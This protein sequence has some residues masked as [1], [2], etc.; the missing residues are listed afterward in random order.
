MSS[1]PQESQFAHEILQ[2]YHSQLEW[3]APERT[4]H[5]CRE[6]FLEQT[7]RTLPEFTT[8]LKFLLEKKFLKRRN[9]ERLELTPDGREWLSQQS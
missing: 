5:Q 7:D 6:H 9:D 4:I 2:A 1:S 8:G 3:T